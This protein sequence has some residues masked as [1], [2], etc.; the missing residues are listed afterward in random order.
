MNN[1]AN[2]S[3][4]LPEIVLCGLIVLLFILD[5]TLPKSG[6]PILGVV[7][8]TGFALA[9]AVALV[10]RRSWGITFHGAYEADSITTFFKVFFLLCALLVTAVSREYAPRFERGIAEYYILMT[11]ATLGM[12]VLSAAG[13]LLV[14]F[15]ALEL[16]TMSFYVM[17]AYHSTQERSLEAG[18][19][20]LVM[21]AL[22]SAVLLYGI[23]FVYGATG[24]IDFGVI[25]QAAQ[26]AET[27]GLLILGLVL[28][29][30]GL[31]FKIACVPFQFWAPDVY[32]GAPT[33]VTAFLSVG[34]KAAGF[35]I[36]L[37][38]L[39]EVFG[40]LQSQW[41]LATGAFAAMTIFYGNLG[42]LRQHNFKRLLAYSSIGHAGNLLIGIAAAS[43]LGAGAV[44]FYLTAYLF[45]NL[46]IF[47]VLVT[48]SRNM[49]SEEIS[50][51]SGLAKRSP[52]LAAA[53]FIA[54]LSLAGVP[55]LAG[56]T[57][58]FF[59]LLA[60]VKSDMVWLAVIG[61][62]NVVISLYY[63]LRIINTMYFKEPQT[64]SPVLMGRMTRAALIACLAAIVGLGVIGET[65]VHIAMAAVRPLF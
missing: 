34:S 48:V 16:V 12:V 14:F 54:L 57:G 32:E 46:A 55:P 5:L 1:P 31:G 42:A 59:L 38:L 17:T 62:V 30:S 37:R 65:F 64:Q 60:A 56:F 25:A 7:T 27:P 18:T 4:F 2:I 39:L 40:G 41:V 10:T 3:L 49:E 28:I 43:P 24:S 33:P 29:L 47:L 23:A 11:L 52:F 6:K 63:Y 19:K 50:H 22:S 20:Y 26:R 44:V 21:G 8:S 45:T 53:M 61:A 15:V 58:K 51:F 13:N 36:L 35:M 9:L